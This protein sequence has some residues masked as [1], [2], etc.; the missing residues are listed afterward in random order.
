MRKFV[1]LRRICQGLTTLLGIVGSEKGMGTSS[2][3]AAAILAVLKT[4]K[5]ERFTVDDLLYQTLEVEQMMNTGKSTATM[6]TNDGDSCFDSRE[7]PLKLTE[8]CC[9]SQEEDGKTKSG[10]SCQA[11]K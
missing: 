3:L 7:R 1:S 8:H 11:L 6:T 4:L 2:I 10:A 9:S 5:G